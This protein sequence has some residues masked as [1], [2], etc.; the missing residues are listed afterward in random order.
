M[1]L[2]AITAAGTVWAGV[3]QWTN[4]GP[5]GGGGFPVIDIVVPGFQTRQ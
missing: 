5:E 2:L 1:P 4:V 3:N